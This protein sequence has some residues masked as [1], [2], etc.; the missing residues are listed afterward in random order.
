MQTRKPGRPAGPET[1]PRKA[2]AGPTPEHWQ[3]RTATPTRAPQKHKTSRTG[4]RINTTRNTRTP[5]RTRAEA[6]RTPARNRKKTKKGSPTNRRC[7]DSQSRSATVDHGPTRTL[8]ASQSGLT[9][10]EAVRR[11]RTDTGSDG[12]CFLSR[13]F[14]QT[15]QMR[16][17]LWLT[18]RTPSRAQRRH[19]PSYPELRGM[20]LHAKL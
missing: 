14:S 16:R 7:T 12:P 13:A 9:S 17:T 8:E 3:A 1:H 19:T 18:L 4:I 10:P 15:L 5:A 2:P 20:T 11:S 6:P